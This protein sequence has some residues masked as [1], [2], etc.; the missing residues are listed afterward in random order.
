M[1][2]WARVALPDQQEEGYTLCN[3]DVALECFPLPLSF[4]TSSAHNTVP[5]GLTSYLDAAC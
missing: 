3:P 1:I 4:P 5:E 2:I